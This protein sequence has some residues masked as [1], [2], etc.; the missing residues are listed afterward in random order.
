[1]GG[2]PRDRW[3]GKLG[4]ILAVAGSAVG[5]GNFL[6]FPAQAARNGGG[7]FM[8]PYVVALVLLGIPLMWIEWTTGRYGGAFGHR[9]APGMFHRLWRHP[10]IKY[11]GLIGIFGPIVI[12]IY[13]TYIESWT[14]AYAFF[15][16][17][18][19]Y[20]SA[21]DQAAMKGFLQS[22]QGLNQTHFSSLAVA[23]AFFLAT[24]LA[25]CWVLF[26]GIT[27]GIE[28]LCKWAMPLLFL[29][30]I[31]LA[32]R[33]LTLPAHPANPGQNIL[34]G[35]GY[36]WN[37]DFE[38]LRNPD[39]WLA[40]AGQIFF[41][42][43]VGIGVILTYASYLS[44]R[45]DVVL[46]GLSAASANEFAEVLLGGTIVLPA[47]FLFFGQAQMADIA[48]SGTFNLGFVTMPLI[49]ERLPI[50]R[51][52]GAT[53][54]TGNLF[55]AAWFLLLFLAGITSSVSL[56]QPAVAFL[57]DELGITKRKAAILFIV[58]TFV[59]CQPAI[60]FLGN[61]VVDELDFWGGTFC[62][63]LF[64]TIETILFGWFFGID[65]AWTE[66]HYGADLRVPRLYR[67]VIKYVTPI[68]LLVILSAW[69]L[70]KGPPALRPGSIR[71]WPAFCAKLR[72]DGYQE[73]KLLDFGDRDLR[74]RVW[75]LLPADAR[76]AASEAA[77]AREV[78]W[79]HKTAILAGLNQIMESPDLAS[80]RPKGLSKDGL[81]QLNR[82]LLQA[83]FPA[84]IAPRR[85]K[86]IEVV[87][88]VDVADP[89]RPYV[90]GARLMLLVLFIGLVVGLEI[91]WHKRRD[92]WD[93][94]EPLEDPP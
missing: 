25:N 40:A 47:A 61:G 14:L 36:M 43:S 90:L 69:F 27:R 81:Q 83:A 12:F 5:L 55:G 15:S 67:Y 72:V 84:E 49:F 16:L 60:F 74:R 51:L 7:A 71:D 59:L 79:A 80:H 17:F 11:F 44:R 93:R 28:W 20:A 6:R 94:T 48:Q 54:P 39:V 21:T 37:P 18:G 56:A 35:L 3:T 91:A 29:I 62:L 86:I 87:L 89:D 38:A 41:T 78:A 42:L 50:L 1:M 63:V 73:G 32:V 45:D 19:E 2:E 64:A 82:S 52:F 31:A 92:L 46:S 66:M 8:I 88:M 68:F 23:Y 76:A 24:F 85:A 65:K 34:N 30:A 26:R 53:L 13:Y 57:K 10:A 9:T 70:Q 33:V 4:I 22:Y 77:N 75:G 58:V